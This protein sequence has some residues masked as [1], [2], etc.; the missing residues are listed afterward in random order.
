MHADVVDQ[1]VFGFEG[2]ALARTLLPEAD[3]VTLLR[4]ADVLHSDVRD[5]LVHGAESFV[6]RLFGVGQ[7]LRLDPLADELLFDGLA[8]VAEEGASAV[9]SGH[10]HV[11]GPVAVQLRRGIV[12]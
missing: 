10:V 4:S 5:Q 6:A 8:H 11:H 7:L 9:V 1:F 12:L 2:L 3:V